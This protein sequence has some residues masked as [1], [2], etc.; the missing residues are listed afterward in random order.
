[1]RTAF[2]VTANQRKLDKVS[3]VTGCDAYADF[4]LGM[5]KPIVRTDFIRS[6]NITYREVAR[7]SEDF[8]YLVEFFAAGGESILLPRPLYYWRQTFGSISRRWTATA[9]SEWRYDFLSGARANAEVLK[10]M[11]ERDEASLAKLLHRRMWA[12]YRLHRLQDL[13]RQRANGAT[14]TQLPTS[15]LRH[16]SIWPLIVQ[17]GVR[18]AARRR[19]FPSPIRARLPAGPDTRNREAMPVPGMATSVS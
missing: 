4:D 3:F 10:L 17:R 18:R 14:P 9:G 6:A 12:F 19:E 13:S 11:S 7:Q 16:P 1:V 15:V 8:L 2:A 5:L